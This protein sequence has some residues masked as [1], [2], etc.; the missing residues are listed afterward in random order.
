MPS[1]NQNNIW[2]RLAST[3][4]EVQREAQDEYRSW[5]TDP[6]T[7]Q[8]INQIRAMRDVITSMPLPPDAANGNGLSSAQRMWL[9]NGMQQV[10]SRIENMDQEA[11]ILASSARVASDDL[12]RLHD[13]FYDANLYPEMSE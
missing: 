1:L 5:L 4:A 9:L 3:D 10:I 2:Y 12:V 8:V 6:V 13:D 7:I 11:E